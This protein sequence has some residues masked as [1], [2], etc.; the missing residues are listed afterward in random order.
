VID[1]MRDVLRSS[2]NEV[3]DRDDIMAVCEQTVAQVRTNE[4][5]AARD[6]D[7]HR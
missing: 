1:Q 6:E 7:A 3:I 5:R 2:G 4:S